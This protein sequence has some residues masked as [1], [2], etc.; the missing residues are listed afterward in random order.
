MNI[1]YIFGGLVAAFIIVAILRVL[2]DKLSSKEIPL[3][4][5]VSLS[6]IIICTLGAY[7]H[8]YDGTPEWGFSITHYS[9]SH[10]LLGLFYFIK[11]APKK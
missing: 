10:V 5:I 8:S 3:P 1:P 2:A 4:L 7:G 6:W 11:G 9:I